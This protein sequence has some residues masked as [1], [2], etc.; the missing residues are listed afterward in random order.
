CPAPFV[1]AELYPPHGGQLD[2]RFCAAPVPGLT[3][4][5]PCPISQWVF[6]SSFPTQVP[7]ANWVAVPSFILTSLL[8]LTYAF[9]PEEKSHRHYLSIGLT[10]SLLL[11][12]L[13]FIVPLSTRPH[14][15]RDAITPNNMYTDM[16]CAWSGALLQAGAMGTAVWILL[17]SIWTALRIILDFKRTD[18]FRTVSLAFGIGFPALLLAIAMP[19]TGVSYRLWD[20]CIP[21][22]TEAFVTWFVWL[23]VVAGLAGVILI[24]T[25]GYCVWKFALS[26]LAG[27]ARGR[28]SSGSVGGPGK[29]SR[30]RA[31]GRRR[32]VEWG[33]IKR[34]LY[35]QWRTVVFAF[36]VTN[37]TIFFALVFVSQTAAVQRNIGGITP[38]DEAWGICLIATGGDSDACLDQSSGLGLSEG[39]VVAVLLLAAS[40]GAT[41][42]LLMIRT[43]MFE[44]W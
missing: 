31:I 17:R 40:L 34:V 7:A 4:C 44:G 15:C 28:M 10:V 27:S 14:Q 29:N 11:M 8:L 18:L 43:S 26:A 37:E 21:N 25:V 35:L 13:A 12:S 41:L 42:S 16:S 33:R 22:G 9:L 32:R 20:V 6:S 19:V 36:I 24:I 5:L 3:C 23:I 30:R 2:A 1:N 38:E 39:R